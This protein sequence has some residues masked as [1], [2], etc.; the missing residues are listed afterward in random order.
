[1]LTHV[2]DDRI[3]REHE[4]W[5]EP[6]RP[7]VEVATALIMLISLLAVVSLIGWVVSR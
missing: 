4:Q 6:L 3:R 5:S 7:Q 2:D 1:M